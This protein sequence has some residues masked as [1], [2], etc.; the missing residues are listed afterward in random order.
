MAINLNQFTSSIAVFLMNA[1]AETIEWGMAED[2]SIKH[3]YDAFDVMAE[4]M[5]RESISLADLK[6]DH[7]F[8]DKVARELI[9]L[10]NDDST[11]YEQMKV[12]FFTYRSEYETDF[13]PFF[14][15]MSREE[16]ENLGFVYWSEKDPLMLVP[17]WVYRILPADMVLISINGDRYRVFD[18]FIRVDRE[19]DIRFGHLGWGF[20]LE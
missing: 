3:I 17:I 12:A 1:I 8:V 13:G 9:S 20:Y 19:E 10:V 14:A 2:Q 5:E 18:S 6:N 16:L 4:K 11:T 7:R 15:L